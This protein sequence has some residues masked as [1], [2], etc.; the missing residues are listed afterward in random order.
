MLY[1]LTR[2]TPSHRK[3][4]GYVPAEDEAS[5][6]ATWGARGLVPGD[7]L[8]AERVYGFGDGEEGTETM[9]TVP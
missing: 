6:L 2:I 8:E 5:A 7:W 3:A 1:K 4:L 9:R